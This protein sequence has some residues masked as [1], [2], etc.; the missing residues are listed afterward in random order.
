[1]CPLLKL[2]RNVLEKKML[3]ISRALNAT[4]VLQ[5]DNARQ[6]VLTGI[7]RERL[8]GPDTIE[9]AMKVV[10][11]LS[12]NL[13]NPQTLKVLVGIND[14]EFALIDKSTNRGSRLRGRFMSPLIALC[15]QNAI[16]LA[17]IARN[18]S[19]TS[20][21]LSSVSFMNPL[22]FYNALWILASKRLSLVRTPSARGYLERKLP[23]L[24]H[25]YLGEG[26]DAMALK[27]MSHVARDL[28]TN[29]VAVVP[30]ENYADVLAKLESAELRRIQADIISEGIVHL[31]SYESGL[32]IPVLLLYI[33]CPIYTL[34]LLGKFIPG[35]DMSEF[36]N[37]ETQGIALGTWV[38]DR[39]RD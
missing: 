9:E 22:Q 4:K 29:I 13:P 38:R 10:D 27:I 37:Y 30:M 24:A 12:R 31:E 2:L 3:K 15:R 28:S 39:R 6:L 34:F 21:R 17:H 36:G 14:Q 19:A 35:T 26:S 33:M 8:F 7:A 16:P 20:C 23:A 25:A 32:W 18:L 5:V 11:N 1:V